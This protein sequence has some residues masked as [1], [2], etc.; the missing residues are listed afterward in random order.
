MYTLLAAALLASPLAGAPL[1]EPAPTGVTVAWADA[2]HTQAVVTWT[3]T[4]DARNLVRVIGPDGTDIY[5]ETVIVEA[6][7]PNRV[8][9]PD[10]K[11]TRIK[12]VTVVTVDAGDNPTSAPGVSVPFDTDGPPKPVL[13]TLQPRADDSVLMRWTAGPLVDDTPGDPLDLPPATPPVF[14][15]WRSDPGITNWYP[16]TPP[17]P[18]TEIGRAS[19]RERVCWI[20]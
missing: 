4:G 14:T 7:Q 13:T 19:C 5:S 15:P 6:G 9:L 10:A 1:A 3:E 2:T 18:A 11:G 17:G 16:L 20:V 8:P 12:R